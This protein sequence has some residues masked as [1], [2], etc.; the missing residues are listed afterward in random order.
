MVWVGN[1]KAQMG[2][3][4]EAVSWLRRG[5]EANRNLPIGHFFLAA[6]L[7]VVN[8]YDDG[9]NAARAGLVLDPSFTIARFPRKHC[10]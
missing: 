10:E 2:A 9:R 1:G 4:E 5:I 6:A 8:R 7:A 3:D